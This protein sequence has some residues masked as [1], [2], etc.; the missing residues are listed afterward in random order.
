[1]ARKNSG[2]DTQF[3]SAHSLP[4]TRVFLAIIEP[5]FKRAFRAIFTPLSVL[6]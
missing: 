2:F 1:M 3:P 5:Y 6:A 4:T